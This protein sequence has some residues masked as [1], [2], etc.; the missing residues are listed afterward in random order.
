MTNSKNPAFKLMIVGRRRSEMT[1][2]QHRHHILEKHGK[3]VLDL[4]ASH[5]D[6]APR[7]YAQNRVVDG[8]WRASGSVGDPFALT[9]DF[10]TQVWFDTPA[11]AADALSHPLY[12]ANLQPD[13]DRFVDQASV[14]KLAVREQIVMASPS[15]TGAVKVFVFFS[16]LNSVDPAGFATAWQDRGRELI[17]S[18][19]ADTVQ[20]YVQNLVMARP[21][22][23]PW[24]DA[25]DEFWVN[26]LAAAS[27]LAQAVRAK[28]TAPLLA[29]GYLA[30]GSAFHLI[31]EESLLFAGA[32]VEN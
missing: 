21:G 3:I 28:I 13:E 23:T 1:L 9:R 29:D 14:V 10:V 17:E 25:I 27:T 24:A 20:R 12:K 5:P 32:G 2:A 16:K 22:E 11:H 15:K 26:D 4:I 7:R 6:H 30:Q 8:T 31:A 19:E 18:G